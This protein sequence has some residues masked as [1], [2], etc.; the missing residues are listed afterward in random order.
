M[1]ILDHILNT[2]YLMEVVLRI[3]FDGHDFCT[4]MNIMDTTILALTCLTTYVLG[5]L[6]G[7]ANILR[8]L[9]ILRIGKTLRVIRTMSQFRHLRVLLATIASS[10]MSLFW[11]MLILGLCQLI[12]GLLLCQL[13]QPWVT[14]PA[15]DPETRMWIDKMYGT[16][17]KAFYSI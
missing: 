13:L 5:N 11:S 2:V 4:V 6:N 7:T 17:L 3:T 16:S 9:K 15:N 12:F 10:L 1:S 8:L 14:N